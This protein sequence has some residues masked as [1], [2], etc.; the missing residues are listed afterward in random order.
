[1]TMLKLSQ[2]SKFEFR[3]TKALLNGKSQKIVASM[4]TNVFNFQVNYMLLLMVS[5]LE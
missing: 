3:M 2:Y 5:P 4:L 1:M